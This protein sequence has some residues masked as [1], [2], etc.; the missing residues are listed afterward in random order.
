MYAIPYLQKDRMKAEVGIY[1]QDQWALKRL[2]LSMGLRYDYL[3]GHVPA[4]DL[5][6]GPFVP[7]RHVDAIYK[8]PEWKDWSPR[9]GASYD[10]F[11]NARTAL[12]ISL[13]RY[14]ELSGSDVTSQSNPLRAAVNAAARSW[15]DGDR[16]Y[17]PDCDLHNFA[18][19]GECGGIDNQ[20]FGQ[21]NPNATRLADDVLHDNRAY[22]W[23]LLAE[24]QHELFRGV[25]VSAGYNRNWD[26]QSAPTTTTSSIR[27]TDNLAVTPADYSPYCITAPRDPRLPEGGGYQVCGLYDVNPNKFGQV[28]NLVTLDKNYGEQSRVWNGFTFGMNGRFGQGLRIG[29]SLDTARQVLDNCYVIDSP[30]QLVNC[31]IVMPFRG[32]TDFRIQASYPLPAGFVVSAIYQNRPG[33]VITADYPASNAEI[34]PSLGRNLAGGRG[35]APVPLLLPYTEFEERFTQLDLRMTKN[36]QVGKY[37]VQANL[38]LYN[39]MNS[40]SIQSIVTTFG[41]RW[42]RPLTVLDGRLMQLSGQISF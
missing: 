38:D 18:P 36:L 3:T 17:I 13:G 8:V 14:V 10:L 7:A 2:T 1:A 9:V 39:A 35:S 4:I 34:A 42:R 19:N 32:L 6:A 28:Q 31:H 16:D 5:P 27:V 41:P 26:R 12:K 30:Q 40:N 24:M 23:D 37:R 33:V 21:F 25:S 20:F 11:G 29:A 15:T 22:T